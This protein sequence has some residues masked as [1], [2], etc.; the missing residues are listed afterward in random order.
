MALAII[1]TVVVLMGYFVAMLTQMLNIGFGLWFTEVIVFFGLVYALVSYSRRAPLPYAGLTSSGRKP[2]LYGFLLGTVNLFAMVV[3]LQY[4]SQKLLPEAWTLTFDQTKIFATQSGFELFLIISGVGLAAPVCEEFFFRGVLQRGLTREGEGTPGRFT[5]LKPLGAIILTGFIFSAFHLDPVGFLARW[6]LGILFGWLAYRSQSL[7][8]GIAAHAANNLVSSGAYFLGKGEQEGSSDSAL[9]VF[10]LF[11]VGTVLLVGLLL[12]SRRFK[13][14]L[15]AKTVAEERATTTTPSLAKLAAP[16][17]IGGAVGIGAV[18]ALDWRGVK[19]NLDD[20]ALYPLKSLPKDASEAEKMEREALLTLRKKARSGELPMAL[21]ESERKKLWDRERAGTVPQRPKTKPEATDGF[22]PNEEALE[23]HIPL[24]EKSTEES[25]EAEAARAYGDALN[26]L[27]ADKKL[28]E[29]DGVEVL[30][31]RVI[32]H[33]YGKDADDLA[34]AA[35]EA[36]KQKPLP[37]G[38]AL[39]LR[40]GGSGTEFDA[41]PLN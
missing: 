38:T 1:A 28:G 36:A 19:L 40:H 20:L 37:K 6:E 10:A 35:K 25:P 18:F 15:T 32:V 39:Q 8:P 27:L 41:E 17:I 5:G 2:I 11:A 3:P 16:W 29:V 34:Q 23:V 14:V 21:Y 9:S 13:G 31:S 22:K 12:L 26:K 24:P 4:V 30:P 7:W 33:A